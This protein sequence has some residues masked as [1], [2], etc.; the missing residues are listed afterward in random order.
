M[1][2]FTGNKTHTCYTSQFTCG[3]GRCI[4]KNWVCDGDDD[5]ADNS[6]EAA[7]LNCGKSMFKHTLISN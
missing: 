6:D 7:D 2:I 3:N 1:F 4:A 5:C